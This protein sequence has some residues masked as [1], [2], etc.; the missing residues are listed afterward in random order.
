MGANLMNETGRERFAA[1]KRAFDDVFGDPFAKPEPITGQ[2][3]ALKSRGPVAAMKNNFD[4]GKSTRNPA[5]P[6]I[7]DFFCDVERVAK[8]TLTA[9]EWD[10][11]VDVYLYEDSE[12][13]F[14]Q[15]ERS[16]IEQRLGRMFRANKISPISRYFTSTRRRPHEHDRSS[17]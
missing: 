4:E 9:P 7:I 14:T 13:G 6:N 10:K 12:V 1:N 5:T 8:R 11:F 16:G 3:Q 17:T 2:Y 15:K